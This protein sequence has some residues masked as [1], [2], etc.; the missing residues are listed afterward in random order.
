MVKPE[1]ANLKPLVKWARERDPQGKAFGPEWT[2][3]L[4]A[5]YFAFHR[6]QGTLWA[7][8]GVVLTWWQVD[9]AK[10]D[11]GWRGDFP[12]PRTDPSAPGVYWDILL[13]RNVAAVGQLVPGFKRL[14][15]AWRQMRW[16]GWR[17]CREAKDKIVEYPVEKFFGKLE[18][19]LKTNPEMN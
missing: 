18:K 9:P 1:F 12:W 15:P 11:A 14:F 16:F 4:I 19:A 5:E 10:I 3:D 2:D 6:L 13:A 7:A 8:P 17:K